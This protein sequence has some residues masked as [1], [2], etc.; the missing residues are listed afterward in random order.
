[1]LSYY[2]K[3]LIRG[4]EVS[5]H[6]PTVRVRN[7]LIIY[8]SGSTLSPLGLISSLNFFIV[9][10]I[11]VIAIYSNLWRLSLWSPFTCNS[12]KR[13]EPTVRTT[14]CRSSNLLLISTE[15][16]LFVLAVIESTTS[17]I[18]SAERYSI[19]HICDRDSIFVSVSRVNAFFLYVVIDRIENVSRRGTAYTDFVWCF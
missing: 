8:G 6:T 4:W 15:S 1:M 16:V 5:P 9:K 10:S 13:F 3:Q 7:P 14:V 17:A 18:R 2:C 19:L 12:S 11:I